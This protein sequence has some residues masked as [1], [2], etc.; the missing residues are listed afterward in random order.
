MNFG[1]WGFA[2]TLGMSVAGVIVFGV[3]AVL[4]WWENLNE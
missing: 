2:F 4:D 3:W 1:T